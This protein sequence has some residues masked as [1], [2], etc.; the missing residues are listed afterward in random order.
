MAD[1]DMLYVCRQ[2]HSTS[3]GRKFRVRTGKGQKGGSLQGVVG[4]R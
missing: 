3:I 4:R 2:V 1:D